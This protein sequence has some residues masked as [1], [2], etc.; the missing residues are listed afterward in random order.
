MCVYS[1]ITANG[2]EQS[3]KKKKKISLAWKT[4]QIYTYIHT[5][6]TIYKPITGYISYM[7]IYIL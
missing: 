3:K 7:Y 4:L 1:T 2:Y 6:Y 5:L